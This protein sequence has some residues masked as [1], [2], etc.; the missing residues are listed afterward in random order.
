[1]MLLTGWAEA[2]AATGR[3]AKAADENESVGTI[4]YARRFG[5][6]AIDIECG[7][8][9]DPKAP[10]VAYQAIRNALRYLGMT[11]ETK[12]EA[13]TK[14]PPLVTMPHVYYR[15]DEGKFPKSWKHLEKV[16]KGEP[17]A[18][19]QDKSPIEAPDNGFIIMPKVN[20]PIGEEWFYFGT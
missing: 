2:Y 15:E 6:T 4:E 19:R 3:K 5:A 10:E 14:K 16:K 9:K 1:Y 17:M 20:A 13:S 12:L 18:F 8:H 7:Q 11:S